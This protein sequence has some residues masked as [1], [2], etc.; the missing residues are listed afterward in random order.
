MSHIHIYTTKMQKATHFK[1][2]VGE[3]AFWC[4]NPGNRLLY[5]KCC[6]KK[7]PAKNL[8]IQV[9]YDAT[10]CFCAPGKGCKK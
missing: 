1:D 5:A 2:D 6:G 7:R 8:L 4:R 10:S 9:Y 3:K